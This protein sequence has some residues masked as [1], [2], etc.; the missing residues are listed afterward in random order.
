MNFPN[1]FLAIIVIVADTNYSAEKGSTVGQT[2]PFQ[3]YV[4]GAHFESPHGHR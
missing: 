1:T 4:A 2:D 3:T